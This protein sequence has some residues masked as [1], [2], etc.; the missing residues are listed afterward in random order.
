MEERCVHSPSDFLDSFHHLHVLIHAMCEN[1]VWQWNLASC[2]KDKRLK[3][4]HETKHSRHGMTSAVR[5]RLHMKPTQAGGEQA[6]MEAAMGWEGRQ[7]RRVQCSKE[8]DFSI[9][10]EI[11]SRQM[12]ITLG[13]VLCSITESRR[14]R[15]KAFPPC[16]WLDENR[17]QTHVLEHLV[18]SSRT[19]FGKE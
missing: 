5:S 13:T 14:T 4:L 1:K 19:C 8:A 11:P 9:I 10:V 6:E 16:A 12:A 3:T 15:F 7:S 17:A 2:I 18:P